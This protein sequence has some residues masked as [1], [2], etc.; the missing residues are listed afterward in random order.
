MPRYL[1]KSI[2]CL[3]EGYT[4]ATLVSDLLA[5][6]TVGVIALP[7]AIAFGIASIPEAVASSSGISPP[8]L[9]LITA[10]VAGFLISALG[11]S[12]VQIGGPTGAF[13]VIIYHVAQ[14]FGYDGLLLTTLMAG[15]I[16][17]IM[18]LA[19]FGS[20]I[21]FIPYPVTTGFTS[22]IAI[23]IAVAQVKDF[24]GL[25]MGSVPAE[26]IPKIQAYTQNILS[27]QWPTVAVGMGSLLLMMASRRWVPRL[28]AAIFTVIV[29]A[30]VVW[31]FKLPVDTI[32]SR[33]G[34]IPHSFPMPS[35]PEISWS[36]IQELVP[37]AT[38]VALLIAIESL[39]SAVVAD[40]M[41]GRRHKADCELVGQG[42]ANIASALFGGL[43]ATGAIARTAANIKNGARTPL[44]GIIHAVTLLLCMLVAASWAEKIPLTTLAAI[45][46]MVAWNM[47]ELDHFRYLLRAPAS[48]RAVLLTTFGLTVFMDLTVA[49]G[50]GMILASLL[51]MKR[52]SELSGVAPVGNGGE[53]GDEER[54][55]PN[56][57]QSRQVPPGV[58]VYEINGPF[59]F[60]V[61]DRLKDILRGMEQTPK[62]FI[63]RVRSVPYIDASG[64]HALEE[65]YEKC[66]RQ[67]TTLL[68]SGVH[69]H[70]LFMFAKSGFDRVIGEQNM[71]GNIDSALNRAREILGLL[72]QAPPAQHQPEVARER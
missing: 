49:V 61:A 56:A 47:S 28:P 45:L 62:V 38:T 30:V 9:G 10:V 8:A 15:V 17:I 2:V 1:P 66:H 58:E 13:I 22:G 70:L 44:S 48:D 16:V 23:I 32:S 27:V 39:L 52:M 29:A 68:L 31:V 20:M 54:P 34:A 51:F 6:L 55:D 11:G 7:L 36:R 60:G 50:V 63:L 3:R 72:P 5:G 69:A 57:I 4:R 24:L 35:L 26:F 33:F 65:F 42:V 59:F 67:N 12:R 64:M 18:G 40:G 14:E 21:K 41:T 71:L 46:F 37:S 25:Q 43:P 53:E 19:R